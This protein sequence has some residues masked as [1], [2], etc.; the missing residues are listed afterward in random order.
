M[1]IFHNP[2]QK[3]R[4][5][6]EETPKFDLNIRSFQPKPKMYQFECY[7]FE[8]ATDQETGFTR[9]QP[10]GYYKL[11]DNLQRLYK[12]IYNYKLSFKRVPR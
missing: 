10:Q 4:K 1:K 9:I 7:T 11:I 6:A 8:E 12:M 5:R 3:Y 2:D